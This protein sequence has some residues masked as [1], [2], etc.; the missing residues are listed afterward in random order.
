MFVD[1]FSK[2]F[3]VYLMKNKSEAFEN[4]VSFLKEVE[5]I[6]DRK[7]KGLEHIEKKSMIPL[8]SNLS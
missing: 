6:F 8:A 1:E 5:N 3:Y 4:F 7:I 2:Y